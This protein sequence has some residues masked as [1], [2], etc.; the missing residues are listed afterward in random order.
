LIV[1]GLYATWYQVN[2]IEALT[3]TF[4]GQL[5]SIKLILAL[6]LL[7]V[8]AINL[9]WTQRRLMAGQALWV[10]RLRTLVSIEVLLVLGI[11][12]LVGA[13]TAVNPARSEIVQRQMVAAI[14]P[15]PVPQPITEMA[16]VDDLHIMLNASP[17]WVGT[18]SFTVQLMD[19]DGNS[20]TNATLIRM[21]FEDQTGKLGESEL[22]IRPEAETPDGVYTVAG[23]N[24]STVGDWR[25]RMT[26]QRPD[27]YDSITD[28]AFAVIA[29]PEPPSLPAIE[30]SPVLPYRTAALLAAGT[31][32]LLAGLY[33]LAQQR[34]RPWQGPGMPASLLVILGVTFLLVGFLT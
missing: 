4:Y 9:L 14:P 21:R 17:G 30:A 20:I 6:L 29:P 1:T 34:S 15:T 3:T 22:Q 10:G 7:V 24:L 8:A 18:N 13:M 31:V 12:L 32:A 19:E 2:T 23:A 28:F 11:L 16:M 27:A 5:L 25:V 33:F 26:V